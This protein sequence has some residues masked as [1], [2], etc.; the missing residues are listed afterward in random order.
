MNPI[1]LAK[2]H[3]VATGGIVIVLLLIVAAASSGGGGGGVDK[4]SDA[5]IA[6]QTQIAIATLNAQQ[7]SG[8][9]AAQLQMMGM[10]FALQRE[11]L[12]VNKE[13]GLA[14]LILQ[15]EGLQAQKDLGMKQL[16]N[17]ID[18][19]KIGADLEKYKAKASKKKGGGLF[20]GGLVG[21]IF[22]DARLKNNIHRIGTHSSGVGLY[23]YE[24][25]WGGGYTVGVMAQEVARVNPSA[26][27]RHSTGFMM[28][29]YSSL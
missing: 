2:K 13:L 28:V 9:L 14:G 19:V 23:A 6:S 7:Q 5:E 26:V 20:S 1:A 11:E 3:P 4:P 17:D 27:S 21:A 16:Q 8:A 22:S 10:Q 18:A 24:Y 12:G 25:A 15:K 29:D